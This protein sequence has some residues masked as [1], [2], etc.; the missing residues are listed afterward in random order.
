VA[1]IL[2]CISNA[3]ERPWIGLV[4]LE[5][6]TVYNWVLY[7]VDRKYAVLGA[8]LS[9]HELSTPTTESLDLIRANIEVVWK[10]IPRV[11][12]VMDTDVLYELDLNILSFI[13]VSIV[14]ISKAGSYAHRIRT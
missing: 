2:V 1:V 7:K 11:C 13:T 14:N 8:K 4:D 10:T 3:I 6:E 12:Q 5:E 9:F